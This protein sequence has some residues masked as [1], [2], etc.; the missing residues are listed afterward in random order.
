[1]V[2]DIEKK[3]L[4]QEAAFFCS[5]YLGTLDDE[6]F[7][8]QITEK[9]ILVERAQHL[10]I[11]IQQALYPIPQWLNIQIQRD[12]RYR[13]Y[14]PLKHTLPFLTIEQ[15]RL[16]IGHQPNYEAKANLEPEELNA[17]VNF[18]E[19]LQGLSIESIKTCKGCNKYFITMTNHPKE[20]CTPSCYTSFFARE[21]IKKL[22]KNKRKYEAFKKDR[23]KYQK[24]RYK[25]IKLEKWPTIRKREV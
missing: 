18:S 25:A 1:M 16:L 19:I 10:I 5:P 13:H 17:V 6:L 9:N 3:K 12:E 8:K 14:Y 4:S 7:F 23:A 11:K 15:G 21:K 20:F 2:S 24:N 22:R